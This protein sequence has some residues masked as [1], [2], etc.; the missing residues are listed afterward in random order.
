MARTRLGRTLPETVGVHGAIEHS[1]PAITF[2]RVNVAYGRGKTATHALVDFNLRVAPGETVALLGP[3][4]SGKSTALKAL[5][6]FVRP[7]SGSVKLGT[8]DI[9]NLPPAQRGIGV[10]VQSYA[11]FPHMRVSE[12]VAF[13]LRAHRVPRSEIGTRVAEALDM[14]G[15]SAYGKRLPR[16]LSGGSTAANRH[17]PSVGNSPWSTPPRRTVGRPGCST[18]REH[19][20]RTGETARSTT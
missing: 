20:R 11:L 7:T 12:N 5:A 6:G 2:D 9:T 15:M 17:C 19:A 3:S 4:G 8:R 18:S 14:V 10:V 16:E 13:G 1:A